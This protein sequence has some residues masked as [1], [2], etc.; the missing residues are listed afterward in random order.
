MIKNR[1]IFYIV[2][3]LGQVVRKFVLN[4]ANNYTVSV[5]DVESGMYTICCRLVN[6]PT[7]KQIKEVG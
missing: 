6:P 5:R 1:S 4:A 2:N 7:N 3:Q